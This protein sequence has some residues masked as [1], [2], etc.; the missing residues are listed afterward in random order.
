MDSYHQPAMEKLSGFRVPKASFILL[1]MSLVAI[2]FI[3]VYPNDLRLQCLVTAGCQPRPQLSAAPKHA[4]RLLLGV[5]T[6]PDA[7]ARRSLVRHAYLLQRAS[8]PADAAVDV[9]F[10]L[11]NLTKEEQRVLVAMEIM[12]YDD[13]IIL[14]CAEN[15]ND[16]K[17]YDYLS[18]LPRVLDAG[19]AYDYVVKT[20]DDT[21]YRL[22]RLAETLRR[23]PREDV[24]LGLRVPCWGK[25]EGSGFMSGMG[26]LLSWDLVEWIATSEV[27]RKKM[28]GPEDIM[29]GAWLNEAGRG[30]N[31]FDMNPRMY[32][33]PEGPDTC[34]RH[35][36]TPDTIAVHKLKDDLK[37]AKTLQYFNVTQGLRSSKLFHIH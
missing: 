23:L 13:I 31:R 29:T 20:D 25:D 12:L 27:V 14:D 28:K 5:F 26:Y 37:W 36:F 15:V 9:R 35:G 8:L 2:I 7:Y 33:Y 11:C 30:R 21:Y 10:V 32:D 34:F 3:V 17:T 1:P 19:R 6:V 4:H 24:Y 22:D 16:G 18:S